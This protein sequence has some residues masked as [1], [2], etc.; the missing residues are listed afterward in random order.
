MI[1]QFSPTTLLHNKEQRM[2]L[3]IMSYGYLLLRLV[4]F[5]EGIYI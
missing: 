5:P 4:A 3:N 1:K 2:S